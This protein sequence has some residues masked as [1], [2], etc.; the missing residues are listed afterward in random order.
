MHTS[1]YFNSKLSKEIWRIALGSFFVLL[2]SS[3][4]DKL[5]KNFYAG[6]AQGSTF[7][8]TYFGGNPAV[9]NQG[10]DSIL[11]A[12]DKSMSTYIETSDISR[13]NN[14][15]S[16]V[17]VD[18]LFIEVLM[19][20][21]QIYKQSKGVFDPTIGKLVNYYGF[22]PEKL[23]IA[24]DT[25][26]IDSLMQYVGLDKVE[27]TDAHRIKKQSPYIYIDFNSIAQGYT[28]DVIA[29]FFTAQGFH[30]FLIEVGGEIVAKGKNSASGKPWRVG[31]DDPK[32]TNKERNLSAIIK[33]QNAGM[34]TSGNYRKFRVDSVTGKK[35]VH[36]I[37]AV[38]G[39]PARNS[40]LSATVIAKTCVMADGYATT[41][42]AMGIEGA[43][44]LVESLPEVEA[45]F[46][47]AKNDSVATFMTDGFQAMLLEKE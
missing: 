25:S 37:D 39:Y 34:A 16:T 44:N 17:V 28:T 31:I 38:T 24:I 2:F 27:L 5:E 43:K 45:Y 46:I 18:S 9:I 30:N 19:A 32:Q 23:S 21:K 1:T 4:Q 12:V 29:D 26:H 33:L 42:M 6:R 14:G 20:S 10:I 47:Y 7:H 22:G 40:M 3:C 15:D 13:I 36:T 41:F 8:I 11:K 35:Y